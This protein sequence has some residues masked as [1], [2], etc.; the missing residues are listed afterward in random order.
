MSFIYL[1]A[2]VKVSFNYL[3]F[4]LIFSSCKKMFWI[5]LES[6]PAV[7]KRKKINIKWVKY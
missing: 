5:P 3:I 7:S 6:N 4:F 2:A 1:S